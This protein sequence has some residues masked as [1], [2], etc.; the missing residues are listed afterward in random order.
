MPSPTATT[1]AGATINWFLPG[2][3]LQFALVA[4]TLA[5]RGTGIVKPTMIVQIATVTLN[6]VLAPVLIAG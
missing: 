6:I 1:A 3:A 5:F 2:I 4:M